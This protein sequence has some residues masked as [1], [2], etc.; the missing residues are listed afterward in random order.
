MI[1]AYGAIRFDAT[2]DVS[3]EWEG[4]GSFYFIVPQV[5]WS[6]QRWNGMGYCN[7]ALSFSEK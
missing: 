6:D 4:Y 3:V 7:S 1:R 5:S 2:S